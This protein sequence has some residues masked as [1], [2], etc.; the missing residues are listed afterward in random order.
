MSSSFHTLEVAEVRR[1]TSEA[2]S[3]RLALPDELANAFR[4][5]PGQHLTLR[6]VIDGEDVRRSYSICSAPTDGELRVAI[7]QVQGGRFSTWANATLS[8]GDK[9]EVMAPHGSFTWTFDPSRTGTYVG[10]AAGSGI[11]PIMSLLKTA[12]TM[13]P[14]SRFL[15]F[16]GNRNTQDVI[17]LEQLAA[18]KDRFLGRLAVHHFLTAEEGDFDILNGRIDAAK[19]D[20]ILSLLVDPA[21]LDAAFVCGP[22]AMM[23]AVEQG[24]AKAGV[25][26]DRV[27]VERF[28][29]ADMSDAQRQAV[30]E[31]ERQAEGRTMRVS[32]DGRRR[33]IA[34]KAENGSILENA[35]A[36]GLPAPFA[37]KAGVCATCRARVVAGEVEMFQNFGLTEKE[38]EQGYILTCQAIPLSDD[39]ELDYDA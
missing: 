33:T 19:I 7:K 22:G 1:E 35:R 17:F 34:Y 28:T 31:L 25:P 12:L 5:T 11:T 30:R 8:A 23:D 39:V 15:L 20:E 14:H 26:A 29:A 24:L 2:I 36:A 18:L 32:I 38:V 9:I 27:L 4:F 37:C 21:S 10:F 6:A 3:M 13:E 16:Y